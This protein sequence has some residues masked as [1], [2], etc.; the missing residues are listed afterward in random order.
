[1]RHRTFWIL[2]GLV[3]VFALFLRAYEIDL[4]PFHNDEGVNFFFLDGI[5]QDGFYRYSHENYHGPS[6]FYLTYFLTK[7]IGDSEFGM[8]SSAILCGMCLLGVIALLRRTEGGAFVVITSLLVAVS[9]SQ[10]FYARYAIH[11][12]LFLLSG[13]L[14]GI[15][16]FLWFRTGQARYVYGAGVGLGILISTKETFIIT[17]F[18]L[19]FSLLAVGDYRRM[20]ETI[21]TQWQHVLQAGFV[22]VMIIV[23]CFS[24]GGQWAG[25]LREMFWAVPQWVGR[26]KSDTGHFKAVNYYLDMAVG[27]GLSLQLKAWIEQFWSCCVHSLFSE[28]TAT[29]IE[30]FANRKFGK[31]TYL[32]VGAEPLMLFAGLGMLLHGLYLSLLGIL[33]A[34]LGKEASD[35]SGVSRWLGLQ[36]SPEFAFARFSLV[37]ALL[38]VGVYSWVDYKTPWLTI[39]LT[40]PVLLWFGWWVTRAFVSA[41]ASGNTGGWRLGGWIVG[42]GVLAAACGVSLYFTWLFN[43]EIPYG[44]NLD[45]TIPHQRDRRARRKKIVNPYSYV[46]TRQGML[47]MT[48]DID[49]YREKHPD[50]RVLI[51]VRSYWPLPYYMRHMKDK[52]AYQVV[53][54]PGR[55]AKDYQVMIVDSRTSWNSEGWTRKYYRLSDV[56]EAYVYFK[57]P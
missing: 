37:W 56:Q 45:M 27:D 5:S 14:L 57:L 15:C 4:R 36:L 51:G 54:T 44:D 52:I 50:A 21:R 33:R 28:Q 19:F 25:G 1:M 20:Y 13:S 39:N 53:T 3:A 23:L 43:F 30:A 49:S 38:A 22:S 10:V 12:T 24:G 2:F 47:D 42:G 11:E 32:P 48:N 41:T 29:S 8:R 26:N 34:M 55:Y 6:Y 40:L 16:L 46:H 35:R 18:C 9:S 17:L 31:L 7:L